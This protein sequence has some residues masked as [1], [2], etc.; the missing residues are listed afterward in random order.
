M[1]VFWDLTVVFDPGEAVCLNNSTQWD[2]FFAV[3]PLKAFFFPPN[4]K[5]GVWEDQIAS[6]DLKSV[7]EILEQ[8]KRPKQNKE[9]TKE[10]PK[11]SYSLFILAWL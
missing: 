2:F 11:D 1:K 3:F 8:G 6:K 9:K 7:T 4:M 10:H 5:R